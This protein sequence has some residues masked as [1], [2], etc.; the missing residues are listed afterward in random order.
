MSVSFSDK[1]K[2]MKLLSTEEGK[3]KFKEMLVLKMKSQK[4]QEATALC[5]AEGLGEPQCI[6]A[7]EISPGESSFL[8]LKVTV[9][10]DGETRSVSSIQ[11]EGAEFDYKALCEEFNALVSEYDTEKTEF[12]NKTA[13][14]LEGIIAENRAGDS[15]FSVKII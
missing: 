15:K 4:A 11:P 2:I 3:E 1:L 9:T 7:L 10:A 12:L 8:P 13:K 5:I 14:L 6:T